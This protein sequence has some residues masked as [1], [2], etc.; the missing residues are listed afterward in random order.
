MTY[1]YIF[2]TCGENAGKIQVKQKAKQ[3]IIQ[4]LAFIFVPR[5]AFENINIDK[6]FVFTCLAFIFISHCKFNTYKNE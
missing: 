5:P 6:Y 4:Y 2:C 1:Y 3:L